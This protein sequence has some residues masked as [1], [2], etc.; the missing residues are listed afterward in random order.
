MTTA[1]R[2]DWHPASDNTFRATGVRGRYKIVRVD[3]QTWT[4]YGREPGG[5]TMMAL[6]ATGIACESLHAAQLRAERIDR[7]PPAGEMSGS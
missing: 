2:L 6:P 4:L 3:P 5:L 7:Q 1:A